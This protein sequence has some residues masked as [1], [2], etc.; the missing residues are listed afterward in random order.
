M[1]STPCIA[2]VLKNPIPPVSGGLTR[3]LLRRLV[4]DISYQTWHLDTVYSVSSHSIFFNDH[5]HSNLTNNWSGFFDKPLVQGHASNGTFVKYSWGLSKLSKKMNDLL[6]LPNFGLARD[7]D[8]DRPSSKSELLMSACP[9]DT[10]TMLEARRTSST[11]R[12]RE[13]EGF[14]WP[15]G[16]AQSDNQWDS[17]FIDRYLCNHHDICSAPSWSR[18]FYDAV[19]LVTTT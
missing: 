15:G 3:R 6:C 10:M 5:F 16:V 7:R 14:W 8:R 18:A 2:I 12:A 11:R 9:G 13:E 19:H 1:P 17:R 4:L